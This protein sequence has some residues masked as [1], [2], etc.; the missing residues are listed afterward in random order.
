MYFECTSNAAGMVPIGYKMMLNFETSEQIDNKLILTR[1]LL[2]VP[3]AFSCDSV[4]SGRSDSI[5]AAFERQSKDSDGIRSTFQLDSFRFRWQSRCT[6][7][8]FRLIR[9]AFVTVWQNLKWMPFRFSL[10]CCWNAVRI[11]RMQSECS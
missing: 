7:G 3:A 11:F 6:R 4:V 10:E 8:A 2:N 1:R 9:G 5:P